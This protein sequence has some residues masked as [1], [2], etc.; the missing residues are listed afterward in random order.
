VKA[1]D[2]YAEEEVEYDLRLMMDAVKEALETVYCQEGSAKV[3][4]WQT[5][6]FDIKVIMFTLL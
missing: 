1:T 3:A 4:L 6:F 5:P 2:L